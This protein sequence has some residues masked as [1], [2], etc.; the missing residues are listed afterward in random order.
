VR[1]V[2][3]MDDALIPVVVEYAGLVVEEDIIMKL[4]T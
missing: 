3:E 1:I 4:D 2:A